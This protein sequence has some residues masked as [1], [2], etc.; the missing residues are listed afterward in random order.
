MKIPLAFLFAF[1]I[2]GIAIAEPLLSPT[3]DQIPTDT[4]SDGATKMT[5]E[6]VADLGGKALKVVFAAGDSFGD[7]VPRV[8]DWTAYKVLRFD[9]LNPAKSDVKLSLVVRHKGTTNVGT[10]VEVPL[11][12]KPGKN[13]FR[14]AIDKFANGNGSAPDLSAVSKWYIAADDGAGPTVYFSDLVLE[15]GAS[16]A[17]SDTGP[18]PGSTSGGPAVAY[19]ITGKIGDANVDLV[20][21]PTV[22]AASATAADAAKPTK[23]VPLTGDPARLVRI[24]AAKMPAIDKPILFDTPEADAICSALEVFPPDN[25]WNLVVSDWPLHPNSKKI[26]ASIGTAKPMRYN[27]DMSFVLVPPDQKRIEVKLG[28]YSGESDKGPYPAPDIMPIEGWPGPGRAAADAKAS[29][30]S[31]LDD[32]QRDKRNEGG[33]RHAIVVDPVNRML[34]EFY[35]AKKTDAGWTA[36]GAAI[37]DLKSNKLRP[38]GWT[39][40]DAAGLPIFPAIVRYDEIQ[41]G[42][43]EHAMRVTVVKTRKAYVAPA[44]HYASPHTDESLPRMGERIRLRQDFDV[45]GFT[46]PVQTILKGLKQYGMFVADNGIDWAISVAPDPRIPVMNDELRKITGADFE[47]VVPPTGK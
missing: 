26:I 17:K 36:L 19:R 42:V 31:S 44:T 1:A 46:P 6:E 40:T 39:S 33:D 3:K 4:G 25:P 8:A 45:T 43:I 47:V 11:V 18:G 32:I 21:T 5:I 13:S 24:K 20:A 38:D 16:D 41:R 7:R 9:A 12:L 10:R 14:L 2:A 15:G 34:Y 27:P 22:A 30:L 28:E 23:A 29:R 37:F 35:A